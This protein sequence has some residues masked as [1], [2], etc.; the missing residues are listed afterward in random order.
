MVVY[1]GPCNYVIN[2]LQKN[3]ARP[4]GRFTLYCY[5]FQALTR[6]HRRKDEKKDR[7]LENSEETRKRDMKRDN[8]T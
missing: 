5:C 2:L 8:E 7:R 3:G 1:V 6:L 4:Y